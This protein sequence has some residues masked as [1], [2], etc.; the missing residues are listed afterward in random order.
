MAHRA[1]RIISWEKMD[2]NLRSPVFQTTCVQF[3]VTKK[4]ELML[5]TENNNLTKGYF[6]NDVSVFTAIALYHFS[7]TVSF[8][9]FH[10]FKKE[11]LS[12]RVL[13]TRCSVP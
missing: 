7:M 8:F 5:L 9:F 10:S 1:Q 12:S 2:S 4:T 3:E 11:I 6:T 13:T